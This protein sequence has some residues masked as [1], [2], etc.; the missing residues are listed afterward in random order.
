MQYKAENVLCQISA[1]VNVCN[2]SHD[3]VT[4][5]HIWL[6]VVKL[7]YNN[8]YKFDFISKLP[9]YGY[10]YARTQI[11]ERFT[12]YIKFQIIVIIIYSDI[13]GHNTRTYKAV[14]TSFPYFITPVHVFLF[15]N[16]F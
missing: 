5:T 4:V 9:H 1:S 10:H 2:G 6:I 11:H 7:W 12:K 13:F 16:M 14:L 15:L 8:L 3:W